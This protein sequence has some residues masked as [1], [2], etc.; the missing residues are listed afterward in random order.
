M[1]FPHKCTAWRITPHSHSRD[2]LRSRKI[3]HS[4]EN[5]DHPSNQIHL[6]IE[7][8]ASPGDRTPRLSAVAQQHIGPAVKLCYGRAIPGGNIPWGP[9]AG[10]A[11]WQRDRHTTRCHHRIELSG[12]KPPLVV[13]PCC[14]P[15]AVAMRDWRGPTSCL[16][17]GGGFSIF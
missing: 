1:I 3:T 13:L 8:D 12:M 9:Q 14:C 5:K 6:L 10:G 17:L 16:G 7:P 2:K 15:K 4:A 11:A